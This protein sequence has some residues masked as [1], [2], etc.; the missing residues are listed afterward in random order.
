MSHIAD[1]VMTTVEI[2]RDLVLRAEKAGYKAIVLTVDTPKLG[3]REPDVRNKFH[4]P[5]HLKAANFLQVGGQHANGV[6]SLQDSGLAQYVGE[7]FDLTLNW[8]DVKWLKS[9]TK[10]PVVVKG[11]LTAEDAK[12]AVEMG[13]EGILVS[14]HGAR[15]LDGVSSTIEALPEVVA[16][17]NGRAEVYMDGG[18]R[19]GTDVFKVRSRRRSNGS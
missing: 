19:R 4:L 6:R 10:L 11:V 13:C 17:V 7:L 8:E 14:N 15:Q 5:P 18:V 1:I 2:T 12:I 16:A 9:I 3:H